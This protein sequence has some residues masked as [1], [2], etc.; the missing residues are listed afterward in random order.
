VASLSAVSPARSESV[1]DL[2]SPV[3]I[4]RN[5]DDAQL[6]TAF[7]RTI[8]RRYA[9]SWF[10]ILRA[11]EERGGIPRS[12]V[13]AAKTQP[14]HEPAC[15]V[16]TRRTRKRKVPPEQNRVRSPASALH[17][18][19]TVFRH[20][21]CYCTRRN[22]VVP[23]QHADWSPATPPSGVRCSQLHPVQL[24]LLATEVI[25]PGVPN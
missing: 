20:F 18:E 2:D 10:M 24:V 6:V 14:R 15:L 7:D 5:T 11:R 19:D 12:R 9:N 4:G 22:C 13:R 21:A 1:G 8:G 17:T 16:W 3:Q 25:P 23:G